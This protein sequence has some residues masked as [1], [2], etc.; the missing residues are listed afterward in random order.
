MAALYL[1][2]SSRCLGRHPLPACW[3]DCTAGLL[4]MGHAAGSEAGGGCRCSRGAAPSSAGG[5]KKALPGS[6]L[7]PFELLCVHSHKGRGLGMVD[8]ATQSFSSPFSL[9]RALISKAFAETG[10][11]CYLPWGEESP[12]GFLPSPQN[13][14]WECGALLLTPDRAALPCPPPPSGP[15]RDM[16]F[17]APPCTALP[18]SYPLHFRESLATWFLFCP[19]H[20]SLEGC[21]LS[22]TPSQP[23]WPE[24]S[25]ISLT[26]FLSLCPQKGT[27]VPLARS[28]STLTA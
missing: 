9:S 3:A 17:P 25:H 1:A 2:L 18:T 8:A 22:P 27:P 15:Q 19:C 5:R 21:R 23:T 16:C 4:C 26:I 13:L 7:L 6:L 11:C 24:K 28:P 14:E 10:M 20:Q 12:A